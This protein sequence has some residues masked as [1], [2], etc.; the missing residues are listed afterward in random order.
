MLITTRRFTEDGKSLGAKAVDL[1]PKFAKVSG[2][3]FIIP[4]DQIIHERAKEVINK[5]FA[6]LGLE[7][8]VDR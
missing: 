6:Q 4:E 5:Y 7:I 2:K 3:A 8:R 1:N